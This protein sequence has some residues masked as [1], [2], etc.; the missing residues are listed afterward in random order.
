MKIGNKASGLNFKQ[1]QVHYHSASHWNRLGFKLHRPCLGFSG[2]SDW[3]SAWALARPWA[4][5]HHPPLLSCW[6]G[7]SLVVVWTLQSLQR[8]NSDLSS[9]GAGTVC[10]P[11][12][13]ENGLGCQQSS[14]HSFKH[15]HHIES[16]KYSQV[17]VKSFNFFRISR[18]VCLYRLQV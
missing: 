18:F 1:F 11:L 6:P 9:A 14:Y 17:W 7:P 10:C 16:G 5:G 8:Y 12:W 15:Q 2:P 3:L 4:L 13:R